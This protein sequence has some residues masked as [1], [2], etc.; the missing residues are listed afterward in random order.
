M[1]AIA[2]KATGV[3][4]VAVG[5][6]TATFGHQDVAA[7]GNVLMSL[8]PLLLILFLTWRV[9]K[10]DQQHRDCQENFKKVQDSQNKMQEQILLT[11]LA[12]KHPEACE[13]P[14]VKAFKENEFTVPHL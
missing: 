1:T 7:W 6:V 14:A 13:L 10:L 12:T 2:E 9:Y 3:V 5:G 8:A 11:F 4:T